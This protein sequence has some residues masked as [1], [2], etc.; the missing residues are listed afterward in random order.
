MGARSPPI[1]KSHRTWRLLVTSPSQTPNS[2]I[3]SPLV[4]FSVPAPQPPVIQSLSLPSLLAFPPLVAGMNPD[5]VFDNLYVNNITIAGSQ[6]GGGAFTLPLTQ[7][8]TFSPDNAFSIGLSGTNRPNNIYVVN[9]VVVGGSVQVGGMFYGDGILIPTTGNLIE[10]RNGVNPQI[11]RIYNT[12]T[13]ASNYE[14]GQL[15]W[16]GSILRLQTSASGTGTA[17]GLALNAQGDQLY[18]Q[19][20]GVGKWRI[21]NA[22]HLYAETDNSFD[23]GANGANRPHNVWIAGSVFTPGVLGPAG[24]PLN[25]GGAG[26]NQWQIVAGGHIQPLADNSY[27]IGVAGTNRVRSIYAGSSLVSGSQIINQGNFVTGVGVQLNFGGSYLYSAS[28]VPSNAQGVNGDYYFRT[29]TPGTA[30][31]RIYVRSAGAWVG[32]V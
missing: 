28:G 7:N 1:D 4:G 17:R 14:R 20:A 15:E 22:G 5:G 24:L 9:Q 11:L 8:L 21:T 23:I 6:S 16:S 27:D 25:L 2:G 31:Q 32:I 26:S 10:Q 12:F 19:T 13:D 18:L 30:N 3:P 29:D